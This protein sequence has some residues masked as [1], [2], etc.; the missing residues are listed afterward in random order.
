MLDIVHAAG[1][2]LPDVDL[3]VFDRSTLDIFDGADDEEG[4]AFRIVG[5]GFA[6]GRVFGFVGVKGAEEGAFGGA[7]RLWMID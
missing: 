6:V 4:L 2:G 7:G 1:V 5:Y 3:H